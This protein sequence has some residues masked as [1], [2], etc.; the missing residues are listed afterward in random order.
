[1]NRLDVS[2]RNSGNSTAHV[3]THGRPEK[4]FVIIKPGDTLHF[5]LD[6]NILRMKPSTKKEKK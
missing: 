5:T 3:G 2:I 4:S 6:D 1:M